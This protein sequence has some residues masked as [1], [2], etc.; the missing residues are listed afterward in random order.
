MTG[1]ASSFRT[2]ELSS[3]REEVMAMATNRRKGRGPEPWLW[4]VVMLIIAAA[5]LVAALKGN[6]PSL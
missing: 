1:S 4:A 2:A 5:K 6:G 3:S